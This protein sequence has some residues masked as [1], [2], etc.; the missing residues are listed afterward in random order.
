MYIT[1]DA[2]DKNWT[3]WG[4]DLDDNG[5]V[6]NAWR[7][8]RK[9][10]PYDGSDR[11]PYEPRFR[12]IPCSKDLFEFISYELEYL[13]VGD[14]DWVDVKIPWVIKNGIATYVDDPLGELRALM[15]TSKDIKNVL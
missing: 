8:I 6:L 3:I 7:H 5:S 1:Y 12:T 4:C 9:Y 11:E 15:I 14:W 13:E 10:D 2:K